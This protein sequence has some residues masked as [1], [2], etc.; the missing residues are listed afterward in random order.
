MRYKRTCG[1]V[2]SLDGESKACA[3]AAV[4][5]TTEKVDA[6][7]AR[8]NKPDSPGCVCAVIQDGKIVHARGYGMEDLEHN[9]A[10]SPESVFYIASMAKQFTAASIALLVMGGK[11][12]LD[13][14]IRRPLPEMAE[15]PKP[16]TVRHLV[17]HMSGLRDHFDLL[18]L[19]GWRDTDY[20][21]NEMLVKL[22][23]RQ[24]T[25]NFEPGTRYEYSNSNYVLL[26]EIV[27]RASG[28]S[29]R[30]FSRER[31]FQPLGMTHTHFD[32]DYREIV[33]HRVIS[34]IPKPGG[35]LQL[36]KESDSYGAGNLLTTVDDLARWDGNFS[37]GQVGGVPL[38]QLIHTR[39]TLDNGKVL[40]Y[41]FGLMHGEYRGLA[42]VQ[43]AGGYK[44]FRA[45]MI[46]FPAQNFTVIVLGNAATLNPTQAAQ[47][48]AD[49]YLANTFTAPAQARAPV[50]QAI[51][52]EHVPIEIDP[53]RFDEL[54]GAYELKGRS[55]IILTVIRENDRF[56][57]QAT[58]Q[59][60][61]EIYPWAEDAFSC[62][63]ADAKLTFHRDADGSVRRLTLRQGG[64]NEAV[65]VDQF[66]VPTTELAGY[67]GTYTSAE[68][69]T[70][71]TLHIEEGR[72]VAQHPRVGSLTLIPQSH[73]RFITAGAVVN[74]LRDAYGVI[75]ALTVSI[76]GLESYV[77]FD[78]EERER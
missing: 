12:S 77:R 7:F 31:I 48:V 43:H 67:V 25:L 54:A 58:G 20:L 35:W 76:N 5:A 11:L 59:R 16:I 41:A 73:D 45:E 52:V 22:L 19:I 30:Q 10:L 75:L 62:P 74:F 71:Y 65:R 42:T 61:V 1:T 18:G 63:I 15:M 40:D 6:I 24:C 36:L 64:E 14:D 56:Y 26:A 17:H 53:M 34:Y 27:K 47:E 23:S 38:L 8:W 9:V 78:R 44:G 50:P 70:T 13:D 72:L 49:V 60:R 2:P 21:N 55:G 57:A 4:D 39:G 46:R 29:L 28:Q 69:V 3:S 51:A 37:S 33:P 68:L 66:S 32:D